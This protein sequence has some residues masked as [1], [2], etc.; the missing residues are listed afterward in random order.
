VPDDALGAHDVFAMGF[1]SSGDLDT[2]LDAAAERGV[3][4]ERVE[5][6]DLS[7]MP[8]LG[9]ADL[10]RAVERAPN[11]R[12]LR[13]RGCAVPDVLLEILPRLS[14]DL[15]VLD[16]SQPPE[17][18]ELLTVPAAKFP[19]LKTLA[20]AGRPCAALDTT[21]LQLQELDLSYC[22]GVPDALVV[23][24]AAQRWLRRLRLQGAPLSKSGYETLQKLRCLELLDLGTCATDV[25]GANFENLRRL[26]WLSLAGTKLGSKETCRSIAACVYVRHL[27]LAQNGIDTDDAKFLLQGNLPNLTHFDITGCTEVN[28]DALLPVIAKSLPGLQT[29]Q[30]SL[31]PASPTFLADAAAALPHC[32]VVRN[33]DH[34]AHPDDFYLPEVIQS[35]TGGGKAKK[36]KKGGGGGKKKK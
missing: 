23:G 19:K 35:G 4:G 10:A 15:E 12:E 31:V 22:P 7:Y 14:P 26:S 8:W 16:V 25:T 32:K 18:A 21:G 17:G 2:T 24:L 29:L 5:L 27:N 3:E 33:Y 30:C 34:H 20:L 1:A 13:L 36:K 11:L 28:A 6:L 9:A